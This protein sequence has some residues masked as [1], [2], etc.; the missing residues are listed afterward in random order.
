MA[1]RSAADR[2]NHLPLSSMAY[3]HKTKRSCSGLNRQGCPAFSPSG[4]TMYF[5]AQRMMLYPRLRA[6]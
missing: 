6:G 3:I 4:W 5:C 2:Y 1:R